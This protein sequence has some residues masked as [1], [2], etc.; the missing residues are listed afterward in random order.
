MGSFQQASELTMVS[1]ECFE[2]KRPVM[3]YQ[4]SDDSSPSKSFQTKEEY[5]IIPQETAATYP[6][7]SSWGSKNCCASWTAWA[8]GVVCTKPT[9]LTMFHHTKA[10]AFAF[11]H[12]VVFKVLWFMIS[13]II[14]I[15]ADI[16]PTWYLQLSQ[17]NM[18]QLDKFEWWTL[19]AWL[20]PCRSVFGA[21]R[22]SFGVLCLM[23]GQ[24]WLRECSKICSTYQQP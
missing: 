6:P 9:R 19:S 15:I 21:R 12:M 10:V 8:W 11:P 4:R 1:K 24:R 3:A 5:Q 14:F 13:V 20:L 17:Q 2:I 16:R 22:S 23:H 7:A 18:V